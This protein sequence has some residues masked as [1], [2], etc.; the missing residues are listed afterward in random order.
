M[1]RHV[2]AL[3]AGAL[4]FLATAFVDAG[5]PNTTAAGAVSYEIGAGWVTDGVDVNSQTRWFIFNEFAGRSYCVE[6]SLGPATYFPL[7]PLVTLY[8]D[9]AGNVVYLSN[10][11]GAGEAPQYRGSRVCYQS[12]LAVGTSTARLF[13]VNVSVSGTDSGFLR[14]RVIDTTLVF[15]M[16]CL[17]N[18]N[19]GAV[20]YSVTLSIA[21][22]TT[23]D[24]NASVYVPGYGSVK[25]FTG[26]TILKAP[27]QSTGNGNI[28]KQTVTAP[29][30]V[31]N[32]TWD[33]AT[34]LTNDGPPGALEAWADTNDGC[35]TSVVRIYANPR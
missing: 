14:T 4:S 18:D 17:K 19:T 11:D 35:S 5:T 24:I 15:P 34:Y 2:A 31:V 1:K 21:N 32:W 25:T 16:L 10:N 20:K 23:I 9:L 28:V 30:G 33:G 7:D 8:S 6:A 26:G 29:T 3:A 12:A 27:N 22:T 13:S